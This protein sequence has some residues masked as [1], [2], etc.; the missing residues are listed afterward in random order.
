MVAD[1]EK[2]FTYH[3]LLS[4]LFHKKHSIVTPLFPFAITIASKIFKAFLSF[5]LFVLESAVKNS[6]KFVVLWK[7]TRVI[8]SAKHH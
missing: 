3:T 1:S 7:V 5:Q 8:N 2:A 4:N 6:D